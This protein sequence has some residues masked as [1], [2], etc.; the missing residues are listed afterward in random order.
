[1]IFQYDL[2]PVLIE[3]ILI[4]F[5]AILELLF[6]DNALCISVHSLPLVI[7]SVKLF[8]FVINTREGGDIGL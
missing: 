4:G 8:F 6:L 5:E 3:R 1:M 7:T 2:E